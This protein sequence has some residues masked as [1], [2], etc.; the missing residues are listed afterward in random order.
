M[1]HPPDATDHSRRLDTLNDEL[2]RLREH[3][4]AARRDVLDRRKL[5]DR[6]RVPRSSP[7]RRVAA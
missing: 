2:D 1:P 5:P 4:E 3:I 6:R 7:G